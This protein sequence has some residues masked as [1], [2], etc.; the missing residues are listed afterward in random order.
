MSPLE[1]FSLDITA[2]E[3]TV[4]ELEKSL[5]LAGQSSEALLKVVTRAVP[6]IDAIKVEGIVH[7]VKTDIK[8]AGKF[9]DLMKRLALVLARAEEQMIIIERKREQVLRLTNE[10]RNALLSSVTPGEA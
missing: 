4:L 8:K 10:A 1:K 9:I 6:E 7:L 2:F 3:Q 5:H